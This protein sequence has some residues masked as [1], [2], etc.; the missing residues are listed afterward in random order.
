MTA[1]FASSEQIT[2]RSLEEWTNS[3]RNDLAGDIWFVPLMGMNNL[4]GPE[5]SHR[6][7]SLNGNSIYPIVTLT[8]GLSYR[9][10]FY[11]FFLRTMLEGTI[12]CDAIICTSRASEGALRKLLLEVPQ[13]F[14]RA[15]GASLSYRGRIV[16]IPLC[17]DTDLLHPQDKR[18]L[19]RKLKIPP[20]A[21]L[22]VTLGRISPLKGDLRSLIRTFASLIHR[23]P[24][25]DLRLVVAG[26]EEKGYVRYLQ[27]EAE[28]FGVG[29]RITFML[30]ISDSVK[31]DLLA[32]AD[33]FVSVTDTL[34]ES[35][36][37]TPV[38]AMAC[39]VPQ[40]VSDWSGYRDTVAHGET[41][42]CIPTYWSKCDSDLTA[43]AFFLGS[44]YDHALLGQ[45]VA[46]DLQS[47]HQH[48]ELLVEAPQLRMEM[49]VS[50]RRRA[51]EMF[52][53]SAIVKQYAALWIESAGL[54]SR[55]R[56]DKVHNPFG[57]GELPYSDL[58]SGYAKYFFDEDTR[59]Q[60]VANTIWPPTRAPYFTGPFEAFNV[61]D[62]SL[63]G[64]LL[65]TL[66][67]SN[68]SLAFGDLVG[69]VSL[70]VS[71][72]PDAIRRHVMW[73]IKNGFVNPLGAWGK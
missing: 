33:I 47:L 28:A 25:K 30:D 61:L 22:V 68:K 67:D 14:N 63:L 32:A 45:T 39:G 55:A 34:E 11:D 49:S 42:F 50:S 52:S 5:L 72:H 26:T 60:R 4:E 21:L 2:I 19:R 1:R 41:G 7:R 29:Q 65:D 9:R 3:C 17:V 10:G 44:V 36:G 20:T 6:L 27:E 59:L 13:S 16:R 64:T 53:Y 15:T 40:V 18:P 71:V 66:G 35:F 57:L 48:L 38:E 12:S 73:L 23:H 24:H 62:T 58:F 31:G 54:T 46:L 51:V 37:L 70:A 8:H 69:E 56:E 43:T